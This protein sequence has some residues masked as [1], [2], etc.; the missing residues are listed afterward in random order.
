MPVFQY[1]RRSRPDGETTKNPR[2]GR[3]F[4]AF[5]A[6][7]HLHL[8]DAGRLAAEDRTPAALNGVKS[9]FGARASCGFVASLVTGFVASP[10][11]ELRKR[12]CCSFSPTF[13]RARGWRGTG[14]EGRDPPAGAR[15]VVKTWLVVGKTCAET[16]KFAL[17]TGC[18]RCKSGDLVMGCGARSRFTRWSRETVC[19]GCADRLRSR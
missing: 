5:F 18:G 3:C 12:F 9:N 2:P 14:A 15:A 19:W 1:L 11:F 8:P 7:G 16:G 10:K 13:G 6:G 4:F 17:E